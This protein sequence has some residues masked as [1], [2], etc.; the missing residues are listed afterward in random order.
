VIGFLVLDE[1]EDILGDFLHGL[2][3]LVLARISALHAGDECLE[4]NVVIESHL[5]FP[6]IGVIDEHVTTGRLFSQDGSRVFVNN[7]A[8][9]TD[10]QGAARQVY[11][12]KARPNRYLAIAC[13]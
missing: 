3:E 6:S 5:Y 4:I 10:R 8:W 12:I 9:I 2:N 11:V 13:V 1:V 7:T